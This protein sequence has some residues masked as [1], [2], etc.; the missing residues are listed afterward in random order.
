MAKPEASKYRTKNWSAYNAALKSRGS[1]LVWFDP[2]MAWF[3][4]I[5][6]CLMVKGLFGL[7]LRKATGTVASLL[8]MAKL[9]WPVPDFS[10]LSRRQKDLEGLIHHLPDPQQRMRR[11]NKAAPMTDGEQVLCKDIRSA[12]NQLCAP[13]MT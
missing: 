11:R 7:P 4:A 5:Q 10:T 2:N 13:L 12:H 3:A 1:L 9:D 8:E 6:F